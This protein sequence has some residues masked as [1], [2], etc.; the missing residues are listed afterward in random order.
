MRTERENRIAE[1]AGHFGYHL[2]KRPKGLFALMHCYADAPGPVEVFFDGWTLDRV[3]RYL[4]EQ[5]RLH[6]RLF[7]AHKVQAVLGPE[8]VKDNPDN[9]PWE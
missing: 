6:P 8:E 3:E 5:I 7:V 2:A 1:A 9:F 4:R